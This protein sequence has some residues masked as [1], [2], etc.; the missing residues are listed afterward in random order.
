MKKSLNKKIKVA[1]VITRFIIGGAQENTLFTVRGLSDKPEY[2]VAFISG[3]S[4]GPEGDLGYQIRSNEKF[5]L[6]KIPELQRAI[7]PIKDLYAFRKLLKIFKKEIYDIV[8]THSS[9]AGILARL[10]AKAARVPVV[11]HTIHGLPFHPH[12]NNF[13]NKFYIICEKMSARSSDKIISVCDAM[14]RKAVQAGVA[15]EDKFITI[16]SGMDLDSFL[17]AKK[18]TVLKDRLGIKEGELIVG[19]IARLFYLKGHK[20]LFEAAEGIIKEIPNVKF[21]LVGDGILKKD[22]EEEL[23]RRN[24][25]DK[26]IFTGL[27][28]P[29]DIPKYISIMDVLVHV[30]LREGL[31]KAIPQALAEGIPIVSFDLDGAPELVKD[32]LTGYVVSSGNVDKLREKIV[33]LLKNS[34]L[35]KEMG[36]RGKEI[37]DPE[38]RWQDM[39]DRID[40]LYKE[41]L[42]RKVKSEV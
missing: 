35:R 15:K 33:C 14:T 37:V 36:T 24:I 7:N 20:Y 34:N 28:L 18:D 17:E 23:I 21:L 12:Q 5:D 26:F 31:A 6:I 10:A 40:R 2:E 27:V 9:K 32:N 38:Y 1:H 22:F 3:P 29:E 30:S 41:L 13:I 19:K 11:I 39:V 42:E 25:R 16:R 8:H 4:P